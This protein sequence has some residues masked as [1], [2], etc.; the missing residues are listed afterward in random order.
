MLPRP[1]LLPDT[2]PSDRLTAS[3]KAVP[4]IRADLRRIDDLRNQRGLLIPLNLVQIVATSLLVFLGMRVVGSLPSLNGRGR[5]ARN[6]LLHGML[7]ESIDSV[8]TT[9]LHSASADATRTE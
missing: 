9:L 5:A 3:G 6:G 4:E 2:L 1:A 7:S 8:R